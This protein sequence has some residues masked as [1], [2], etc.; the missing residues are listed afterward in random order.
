MASSPCGCQAA[1]V[2]GFEWQSSYPGWYTFLSPILYYQSK[3]WVHPF[4][5]DIHI[6]LSLCCLL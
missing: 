5:K 6:L 2:Y 3:G 1:F 4:G